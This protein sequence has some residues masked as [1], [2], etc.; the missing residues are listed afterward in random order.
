M[1]KCDKEGCKKR[2]VFNIQRNWTTF[3]IE[4]DEKGLTTYHRKKEW[5]SDCNDHLCEDHMDGAFD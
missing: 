4:Y 1:V 3:D 5:N 2:A